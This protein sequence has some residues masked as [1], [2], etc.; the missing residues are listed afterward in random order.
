MLLDVTPSS[1]QV[2][3]LD[4][5]LSTTRLSLFDY[6]GGGAGRFRR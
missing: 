5:L 6:I 1:F 4:S 3:R 2:K